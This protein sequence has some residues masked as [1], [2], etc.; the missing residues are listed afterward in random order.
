VLFFYRTIRQKIKNRETLRNGKKLFENVL[1]PLIQG[2]IIIKSLNGGEQNTETPQAK[3]QM[4]ISK[5]C[6]DKEN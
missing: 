1:T 4:K 2:V 6:I 3:K 5:L